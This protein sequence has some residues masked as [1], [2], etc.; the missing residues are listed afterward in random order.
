MQKKLMFKSDI[1]RKF[2]IFA[3]IPS[4]LL[5]SCLI[6]ITISLDLKEYNKLA[7]N[8]KI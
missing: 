1:R 5:A 2:V 3:I 8:N 6:F 4:F 7:S